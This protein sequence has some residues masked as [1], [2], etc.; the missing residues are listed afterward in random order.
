RLLL[1]EMPARPENAGDLFVAVEYEVDDLNNFTRALRVF[2][3]S[4]I[5][6]RIVRDPAGRDVQ[7]VVLKQAGRTSERQATGFRTRGASDV[8]EPVPVP[9]LGQDFI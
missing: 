7:V 4:E 9:I 5:E 3:E 2:R 6:R 8:L 1:A